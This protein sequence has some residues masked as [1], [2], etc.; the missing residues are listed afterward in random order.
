M[1]E[2]NIQALKMQNYFITSAAGGNVFT[3]VGVSLCLSQGS[4]TLVRFFF[5]GPT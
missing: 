5:D 4:Y 2:R 1:K 3:F